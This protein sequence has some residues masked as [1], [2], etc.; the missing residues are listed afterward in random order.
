M[1]KTQE[2]VSTSVSVATGGYAICNIQDI[3]SVAILILSIINIL[4]TL[5][6][7]VISL[8]KDKK[9]SDIG[10]ELTNSANE[11]ENLKNKGEKK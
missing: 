10:K 2:I 3:L 7:R 6:V 11:L 9:Y 8:V 4:W 1:N 5:C